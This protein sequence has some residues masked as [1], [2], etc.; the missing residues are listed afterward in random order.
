MCV[1]YCAQWTSTMLESSLHRLTEP[2]N[3]FFFP[4]VCNIFG[5]NCSSAKWSWNLIVLS[6]YSRGKK[7]APHTSVQLHC[8]IKTAHVWSS[9]S[10]YCRHA[11]DVSDL[12]CNI[13]VGFMPCTV[14]KRLYEK[15]IIRH[16]DRHAN[17]QGA[18]SIT[19]PWILKCHTQNLW[20]KTRHKYLG[21]CWVAGTTL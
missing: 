5:S 17:I 3:K 18:K 2:T 7:R 4:Q 13:I 12:W 16:A 15:I 21:E 1:M 6:E 14:K 10:F 11:E 8:S 19:L 9:F 20:M